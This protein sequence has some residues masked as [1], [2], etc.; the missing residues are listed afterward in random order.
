MRQSMIYDIVNMG[1]QIMSQ[2]SREKHANCQ[3]METVDVQIY[4]ELS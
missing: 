2:V 3:G 4:Y 1:N